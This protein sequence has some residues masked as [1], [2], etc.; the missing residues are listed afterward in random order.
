MKIG[1]YDQ[2]RPEESISDAEASI[3]ESLIG[4]AKYSKSLFRS[5]ASRIPE[6]E[7]FHNVLVSV[8]TD[9][10]VTRVFSQEVCGEWI[11]KCS[12]AGMHLS[13]AASSQG[14]QLAI[15]GPQMQFWVRLCQKF[16]NSEGIAN[17]HIIA[18]RA[19]F[20][21]RNQPGGRNRFYL[22]IN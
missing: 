2:N 3:Q 13:S 6:V 19:A 11:P 16:T 15:T 12:E 7:H 5:C 18:E 1:T 9:W 10:Y 20:H 14:S 17:F 21:E 22:G 4:F 8:F